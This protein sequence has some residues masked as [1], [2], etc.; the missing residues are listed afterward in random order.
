[1]I[2]QISGEVAA[3]GDRSVVIDVHGVGYRVQVTSRSSSSLRAGRARCG[4]THTWPSV[5][6]P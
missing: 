6:T 3:T 5:K 2:A 1:M 4:S